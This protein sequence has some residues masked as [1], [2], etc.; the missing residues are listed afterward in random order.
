VRVAVRDA[1]PGLDAAGRER[2]FEPFYTTKREGMGLG[3]PIARSLVEAAGGRLWV[4][5]DGDE[6]A[7]FV[8]TLPGAG[9]AAPEPALPAPVGAAR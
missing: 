6:G 4:A 8:F 7:S 3:L 9:E 5:D 2:I 1:G